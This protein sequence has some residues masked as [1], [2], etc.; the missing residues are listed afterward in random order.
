MRLADVLT[1]DREAW[2]KGFGNKIISKHLDF[3]LYDPE[4]TQIRAGIELDDRSHRRRDRQDRDAFLE[5]A[6]EVAG[7]PLVRFPARRS[8][9]AGQIADALTAAMAP[10]DQAAPSSGSVR[11]GRS[12][13]VPS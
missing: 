13:R 11:R 5:A 12:R 10:P 8:Y 1:C 2:N 4:S 6:M 9:V 7:I 3:V